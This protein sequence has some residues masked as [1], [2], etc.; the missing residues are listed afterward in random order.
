MARGFN[1]GVLAARL[2]GTDCDFGNHTVPLA[3]ANA[4]AARHLPRDG[5]LR[6]LRQT[7]CQDPGRWAL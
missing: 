1:L 7:Q 3:S 4:G 5:R 6:G 2:Q